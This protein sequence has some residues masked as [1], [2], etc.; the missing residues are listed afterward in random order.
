MT[1]GRALYDELTEALLGDPAMTRATMMGL[2]CVRRDGIFLASWDKRSDHLV[3]KLPGERVTAL[4]ESGVGLP[5]APG[6]KVF[7][8]WVALPDPD[9]AL[10]TDVL[11]EAVAFADSAPSRG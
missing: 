4:V 9:R 2:P 11:A 5:F 6:G 3:V 10:W 7:R 1:D 8:E